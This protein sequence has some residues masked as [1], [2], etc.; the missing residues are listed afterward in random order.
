[1][2]DGPRM[3]HRLKMIHLSK[4][5]ST[6]HKIIYG[7][8]NDQCVK[9][10]QWIK[11][12]LW[13]NNWSTVRKWSVIRG[14]PLIFDQSNFADKKKNCGHKFCGQTCLTI[15]DFVSYNSMP[16]YFDWVDFDDLLDFSISIRV[17]FCSVRFLSREF[18][19]DP[20]KLKLRHIP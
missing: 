20:P 13:I 17:R 6:V 3:I 16:S 18:H 7:T 15:V 2:I 8:K 9:N 19:R 10:D 5:K 11:N 14:H 1:M 12:D 4:K